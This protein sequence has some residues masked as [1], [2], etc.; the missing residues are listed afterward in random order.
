MAANLIPIRSLNLFQF[1]FCPS[2]LFELLISIWKISFDLMISY[3]ILQIT[4]NQPL[5]KVN[6][7]KCV[8]FFAFHWF[9]KT[10]KQTYCLF[11][12]PLKIFIF[13]YFRLIFLCKIIFNIFLQEVS[14]TTV[15]ELSTSFKIS[16]VSKELPNFFMRFYELLLFNVDIWQ[17]LHHFMCS[18]PYIWFKLLRWKKSLH[19]SN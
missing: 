5:K 4:T 2:R 1:T 12:D 18:Q 19:D 13:S 3:N 7:T 17:M 10:S 9:F 6:Y 8:D 14:I 16:C 11:F 15:V